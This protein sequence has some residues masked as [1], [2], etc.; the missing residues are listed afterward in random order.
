MVN[1]ITYDTISV[2]NTD[3]AIEVDQCYGQDNLT[4]CLEFP[5]TV[6]IS[7]VLFTNFTGKTSKKFMPQIGTFACSDDTVCSGIVTE[8]ISVT[9]P[10]G[11]N[12]AYCLNV[13]EGA[14]EGFGCVNSSLGF[15]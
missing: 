1:N 2:D 12:E 8:G 5:S 11:T 7:D 9:S 6:T 4:L 14:L 15:N 13:D 3:Y 10:Q